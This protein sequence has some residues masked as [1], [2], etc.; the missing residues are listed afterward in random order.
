MTTEAPVHRACAD[1]ALT[2]CPHLQR[3]QCAGDLA[4][5]PSGYSILCAILDG[6]L[7]DQDFGVKINGRQV[8]GHLKIAWPRSMIRIVRREAAPKEKQ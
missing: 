5:F 3:N 1:F 7:T 4:P 2:K 8:V 6:S